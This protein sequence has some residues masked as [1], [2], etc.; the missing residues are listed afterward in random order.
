MADKPL[1]ID[2]SIL[3]IQLLSSI[4]SLCVSNISKKS[5]FF[6]KCFLLIISDN[7]LLS[8]LILF[9]SFCFSS[10]VLSAIGFLILICGSNKTVF[11]ITIPSFPTNPLIDN[12]FFL[13]WLSSSLPSELVKTPNSAISAITIATISKP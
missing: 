1:S 3:L 7:C 6:L 10:F 8:L 13:S 4:K 2:D 11:P 5:P 9:F 12:G